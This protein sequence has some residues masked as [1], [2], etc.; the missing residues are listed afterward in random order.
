MQKL[1]NT[2]FLIQSINVNVKKVKNIKLI[3]KFYVLGLKCLSRP[4][5]RIANLSIYWAAELPKYANT[6]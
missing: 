4:R 5:C 1:N 3:K 6:I 2:I